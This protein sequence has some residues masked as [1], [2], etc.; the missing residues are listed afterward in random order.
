VFRNLSRF[1]PPLVAVLASCGP[2]GGESVDASLIRTVESGD[3]LIT[4]RERGEV[5]AAR[6]TRVASEL[7]GRATLIYLIPE[8]TVV[9][10]G[11]RV[12]ELDVSAIEEK[13]AQ[14]A[15]SVA[16][17][18]ATRE[19]A[20]KAVEI[21]EKEIQAASRT[22]ET[23]LEVA[24]LRRDKFVGQERP[25]SAET[26]DGTNEEMLT[27]LREVVAGESQGSAARF[28][29]L[30]ERV[31]QILA[32]EE[33][34]ARE[35]GEM[36]N[37]ILQQIDQIRLARADLELAA[38]TLH[39][40]RRLEEKGFITSNEL[41]RDEINHERQL[42]ARTLAWNDLFLLVNY[43]LPE[44][45]I[46]L[47][48][49]VE[50]ARLNL[51]SVEAANDARRVRE[52][53]EL[54]SI[55]AEHALA[56]AQLETWDRQI[57]NGILRAPA[58]GLVVYARMDWDEPVYEGME[59]LERQE[60]LLLPD[61]T[62]M[63]VELKVPEAQIG[64]LEVGQPATIR[65]DAFPSRTFTGSVTHVARL[66]DNAPGSQILKVYQARVL[67]DGDNGDG[68]LRPGMNG[69]VTIEIGTLRDVLNVPL[70]A[71]ERRGDT[72]Y[73]W[74]VTPRGP[75]AAAVEL[76]ANNLT[77]VQVLAGLTEGERIYLV[78]PPG[79]ELP[80]DPTAETAPPRPAELGAAGAPGANGASHDAGVPQ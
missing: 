32:T 74:K 52:A 53:A 22:A 73:V 61:V 54:R 71:L 56:L 68:E 42:A 62:S 47:D 75:T 35:M 63:M 36:A 14:Q 40:S 46:T 80:A 66:P 39:Y 48:L 79:S 6:D 51:E 34:R 25:A 5:K 8:G 41:Q 11:D 78:R 44:T 38:Q 57:Q 76:G 20:R 50:N 13:R 65:V 9:E 2:D 10:A 28:E 60:V 15:I 72:H 45:L 24:R 7:E 18:D 29:R 64:R 67:I 59:V 21:A 23:R 69:M 27:R 49:E 26:L 16:R 70:P 17:A 19:Q 12:A 58:P 1:L 33:N 30:P 31:I 77:H 43:T 3:L 4:V 37:Q 55:E